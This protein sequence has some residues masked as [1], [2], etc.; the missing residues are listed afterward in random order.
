MYIYESWPNNR[1]IVA[2]TRA[3]PTNVAAKPLGFSTDWKKYLSLNMAIAELTY[4]GVESHSW[5]T[6]VL[7]PGIE[8]RD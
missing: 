2:A 7:E 5:T 6:C 4:V 1:W 8:P 3:L